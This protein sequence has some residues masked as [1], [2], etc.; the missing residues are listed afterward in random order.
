[1]RDSDKFE[2]Q[3]MVDMAVAALEKRTGLKLAGLSQPEI[4]HRI[5]EWLKTK[6]EESNGG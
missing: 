1:M 3:D 5:R 6:Q 4:A 2:W